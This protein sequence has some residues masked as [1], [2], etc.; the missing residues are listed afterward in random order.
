MQKPKVFFDGNCPLCRKEIGHYQRLDKALR[1]SWL[2]LHR[3]ADALQDHNISERE[4]MQVLHVADPQGV[5]HRGVPGFL[6]I[7]EHLPGYRHLAKT[8][9]LLRLEPVMQAAYLR[10][11]HWRFTRRCR[12]RCSTGL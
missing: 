10:F 5:L 4:A 1:I 8:V 11:A 6:I 2:D 9:R 7:W 12:D 3:A